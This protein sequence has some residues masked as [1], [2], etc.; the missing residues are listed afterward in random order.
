[1]YKI[2]FQKSEIKLEKG[3]QQSSC[4]GPDWE[5]LCPDSSQAARRINDYNR[6]LWFPCWNWGSFFSIE[7]FEKSIHGFSLP[8]PPPVTCTYASYK[9]PIRSL[10]LT[11]YKQ[12]WVRVRACHDEVRDHAC[13]L[14]TDSQLYQ[15][16]FLLLNTKISKTL[17]AFVRLVSEPKWR[18]LC[19]LWDFMMWNPFSKLN[20]K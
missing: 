5:V 16:I 10:L 8:P 18:K 11:A 6:E 17:F 12:M 14:S 3:N 9:L 13:T 20:Q 7:M 15:K 19:R 1:M 4:L 2:W